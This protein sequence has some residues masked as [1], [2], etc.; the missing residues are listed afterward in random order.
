MTQLE[1]TKRMADESARDADQVQG[2]INEMRH[3]VSDLERQLA[4]LETRQAEARGNLDADRVAIESELA[5]AHSK[6]AESA[7]AVPSPMLAKY[8]K[9][10]GRRRAETVF[11]LRGPS[12]SACDTAIPTQRRAAMAASGSLE[13]CEGCGALL[14]A[15][16]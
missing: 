9:V 1:Q 15:G 13:M 16:E 6:R 8:D 11:P 2:R 4:E 5:A 12:C 3:Q 7:R 14:Y 10:R